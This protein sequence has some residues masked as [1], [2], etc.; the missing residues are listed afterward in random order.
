MKSDKERFWSKV[1]KSGECWLWT[2]SPGAHGR[3]QFSVEG[4]PVVATRYSWEMAHGAVPDGAEVRQSCG[5][6]LCVRPSH[7]IAD[8][9]RPRRLS[10]DRFW[11]KVTK[12]PKCWEWTGGV[13]Q[14]YGHLNLSREEGNIRA[15]RFSWILHKGDVPE[16]QYVCHRCNN[17]LCVRPDHLYLGTNEENVSDA[18]KDG[19]FA[20]G[21]RHHNARL[22]KDEVIEIRR[23]RAEGAPYKKIAGRFGISV[24]HAAA[25]GSKKFWQ[26][27]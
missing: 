1:N 3:G 18:Y 6:K 10:A 16:G 23:L 20:T 7:L 25:I 15:H 19:L 17:K 27:V 5:H 2:A 12:G 9:N 11:E 14:G 21:E 22:T 26:D 4:R 8:E 13:S 24:S